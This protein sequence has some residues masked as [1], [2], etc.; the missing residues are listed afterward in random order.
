MKNTVLLLV[1]VAFTPVQKPNIVFPFSADLEENFSFPDEHQIKNG[2][3]LLTLP[4]LGKE[5]SLAFKV[6]LSNFSEGYAHCLNLIGESEQEIAKIVLTSDRQ[7]G[8]KF[9]YPYLT[10]D[11]NSIEDISSPSLEVWTQLEISQV[12]Q[13]STT[14]IV[15]MKNGSFVGMLENPKPDNILGVKVFAVKSGVTP[16]PG[17]IKEL[18][19]RTDTSGINI[20]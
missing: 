14:Q 16:Q 8:V 18:T 6:K 11:R 17:A 7:F 13:G 20:I 2:S 3:P 4:V 10:T 19:L 9:G 1:I 15:F 12:V 5:W